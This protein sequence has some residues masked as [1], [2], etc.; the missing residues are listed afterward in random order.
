[1][2]RDSF[3]GLYFC[4]SQQDVAGSPFRTHWYCVVR[5]NDSLESPRPWTTLRV[6]HHFQPSNNQQFTTPSP[7]WSIK[8]P[9]SVEKEWH[10]IAVEV[11]PTELTLRLDNEPP[12]TTTRRELNDA[13]DQLYGDLLRLSAPEPKPPLDP[14]GALGLYAFQGTAS[15]RNVVVKPLNPVSGE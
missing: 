3:V 10:K 15:F 9:R 2:K 14:R 8:C 11:S 5:F 4:H 7:S 13:G 1:V 6:E 12:R